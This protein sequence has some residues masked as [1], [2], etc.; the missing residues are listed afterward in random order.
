MRWTKGLHGHV[1]LRDE[2]GGLERKIG[3]GRGVPE[4]RAVEF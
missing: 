1:S 2:D 3:M 4:C